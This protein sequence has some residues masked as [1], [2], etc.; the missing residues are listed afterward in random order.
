MRII[1]YLLCLAQPMALFATEAVRRA[2]NENED[3]IPLLVQTALAKNPL[4]EKL[5]SAVQV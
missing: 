3:K 5:T 4:R 2:P 1:A